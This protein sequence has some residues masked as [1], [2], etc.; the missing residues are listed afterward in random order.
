MDCLIWPLDGARAE[1]PITGPRDVLTIDE[2][3]YLL[4]G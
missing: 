1:A 4:N 3:I 2:V